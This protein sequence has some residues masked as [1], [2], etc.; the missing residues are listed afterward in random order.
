MTADVF[1]AYLHDGD[2]V[3][4]SFMR[5]VMNTD[6]DLLWGGTFTGILTRTG[7]IADSRNQATTYFLGE[8]DAQWLWF[9][10]TD[11]GWEP[12]ALPM[13]LEQADP[14]KAPF[15]GAHCVALRHGDPDGAGGY[16]TKLQPTLYAWDGHGFRAFDPRLERSTLVAVDGTGAACLLLH[17]TALLAMR[18]G[19]PRDEWWTPVRGEDE[20]LLGEDLSFS[21]RA[22]RAG[23]PMFV[24]MGVRTT[25]AKRVWLS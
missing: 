22:M 13:L 21:Y 15:V 4:H 6:R 20:R 12:E 5:S 17:R 2:Q 10:D 9:V 1:A 8:T 16:R 11:M 14:D 19:M 7:A 3:S 24:H 23:L 18:A 25:H